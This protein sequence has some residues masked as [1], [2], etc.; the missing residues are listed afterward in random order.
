MSKLTCI[1][2]I[3]PVFNGEQHIERCINY[4]L[5]QSFKKKIEIIL[6]DD[7]SKDKSIE[8]I[9][10]FNIPNLKF[11][12]LTVNSGPAAARNLGIKK[13]NGEYLFF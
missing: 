8:L 13:A 11:Y 5:N 10:R 6:I 7:A 3:V 1:S 2:V 12:S 4:L 9:K